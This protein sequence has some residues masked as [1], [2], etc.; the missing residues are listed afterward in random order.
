MNGA[1]LSL[2]DVHAGYL[3]GIDVLRGLTLNARANEI[4]L[5]IGPNGAGKSTLLRTVFAFLA[6]N[7]GVITFRNQPTA[8]KRASALKAAGI[9]YVTQDINSFPNLTVEENLRMGAWVFRRD[10]D[11]LQ[12]QLERAYATFPALAEK[13]YARAGELSGGQGRMLSVAREMMSEPQ[14]LLVDEPTAGLAPNLVQQ[15]YDILIAAKDASRIA[16]L[17]VE[18]NVEQALPLADYLYLLN[19][20]RVKAEGPGRDFDNN[21]V[22]ALIQECLLG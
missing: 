10:K 14:L 22:R 3:P 4:T 9:S 5:V 2:E 19:L 17:L 12:H 11:R 6:P 7:Q 18:Q 16:I 21:R 15:V 1:L 20:G 8:G 13:R